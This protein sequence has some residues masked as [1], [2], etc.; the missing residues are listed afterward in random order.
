[1][2]VSLPEPPKPA[3][4]KVYDVKAG[5]MRLAAENGALKPLATVEALVPKINDILTLFGFDPMPDDTNEETVMDRIQEFIDTVA[6]NDRKVQA[7]RLADH[8]AVNR[9]RTAAGLPPVPAHSRL[10]AGSLNEVAAVI[11]RVPAVATRGRMM[12]TQGKLR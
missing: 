8:D 4:R 2:T 3:G 6:A 9:L 7:A 12:T 11:E 10:L 1:M 5:K